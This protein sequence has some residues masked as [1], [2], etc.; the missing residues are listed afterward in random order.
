MRKLSRVVVIGV[1]VCA[2][3][4]ARLV[5]ADEVPVISAIGDKWAKVNESFACTVYATGDPAPVYL[6]T[7]APGGMAIGATTGVITWVPTITQ[8]GKWSV[9][10]EATNSEGSDEKTFNVQVPVPPQIAPIPDQTAT[11]NERW[12]YNVQVTGG[13]NPAPSLSLTIRPSGMSSTVTLIEWTPTVLQIGAHD[14]T[15]KATS[16]SGSDSKS[17]RITV[18]DDGQPREYT[19]RAHSGSV[20]GYPEESGWVTLPGEGFF[21]YP[22]GTVVPITATANEGYHFL[23]WIGSAVDAGKVDNPWL[24]STTVAMYADYDVEARFEADSEDYLKLTIWATAGGRIVKPGPDATPRFERNSIATVIAAADPGYYFAGWTGTA[25]EAG[26]VTD[27]TASE[28]T[29]LMKEDYSLAATFTA[30][31]SVARHTLTL[32]SG[33]GGAVANPGE[34]A[35]EFDESTIVFVS[36]LADDGYRFLNWTGT[37]VNAGVVEDSASANTKVTMNA[38]YTLTANFIAGPAVQRTLTVSAGKGGS[39]V[40]P[41]E[42]AFQFDENARVS[43]SALADRGYRFTGWSGTAVDA[44]KVANPTSLS[45]TV[46]MSADFTLVANFTAVTGPVVQRQLTITHT[47]GGSVPKPG[48]GVNIFD[49]D[50]V[51]AIVAK[52]D[53]AYDFVN[54][55]GSAVD[56]GKV[57]DPTAASTTVTMDSNYNL[58]AHFTPA[59]PSKVSVQV[60]SPNGGESLA[61][62]RTVSIRWKARGAVPGLSVELSTDGGSTW[63]QIVYCAGSGDGSHDWVV[64]TVDSDSCLIRITVEAYSSVLDTSDAPFSIHTVASRM[65]YVDAAAKGSKSGAS[66]ASA[67]VCLQDALKASGP[68]DS[69]LVAEGLYWPD[70]GGNS[71]QKDRAAA[72]RLKTG[73]SIYG[74]FPA[75]GGDW[76]RRNPA[77]HRSVLTGDIGVVGTRDDNSYHVVVAD[78]VDKT[79]VLDGCAICDGFANG[80]DVDNLGGGLHSQAGSPLIRN[81]TFAHNSAGNGGGACLIG[82][83]ASFV[84]CV[85]TGN[86]ASYCGGGLYNEGDATVVNCTFTANQ[87]MWRG[88]GVF[89][90][91]GSLSVAN[92]ILWGNGRQF[93]SA[94]DEWAQASS[95][96]DLLL[97][98][99]CVQDWTG[100]IPGQCCLGGD[101]LFADAAGADGA[102]GT[103][104]DDLRLRDGSPCINAGDA[105]A[106]PAGVSTDLQGRPRFHNAVDMGAYEFDAA[107]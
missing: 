71:R 89:N 91:S 85:F 84:N 104:D 28:T 69:I 15:V 70:L 53:V 92:C 76:A 80:T 61:S 25:V 106:V 29:V 46:S 74:G 22:E 93:R 98:Y 52:P 62:G 23:V 100:S 66:W 90:A 58:C 32:S 38:N 83:G 13:G 8:V 39:V 68:G 9:S 81:C 64:P 75:D 16:P 94:Y 72:F 63:T 27:V 73:V 59:D 4:H 51:V 5:G 35:F 12:T 56:A 77:V 87:G 20:V 19:L 95:D 49:D 101:P 26:S 24:A 30:I 97:A 18:T 86:T 54:W 11:V 34:G 48:T 2:L 17:F 3:G 79:A 7:S 42:G 40:D 82:G 21:T 88:G 65:W 1:M 37:A 47:T 31:G 6:L 36:A 33:E 44:G 78:G 43:I 14:V 107:D 41:G 105:A 99:C 60:V 10:V 55:T 45:T 103:W 96:S 50:Q 102:V 57:A 67:M